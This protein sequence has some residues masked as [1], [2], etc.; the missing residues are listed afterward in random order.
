VLVLEDHFHVH[1]CRRLGLHPFGL[2]PLLY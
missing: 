2:H 1:P